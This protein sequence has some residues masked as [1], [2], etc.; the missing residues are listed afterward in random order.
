MCVSVAD[1]LIRMCVRVY[2]V[3]VEIYT[4]DVTFH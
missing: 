4:G 1:D 3:T 2:E